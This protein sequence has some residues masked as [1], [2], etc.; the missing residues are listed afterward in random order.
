MMKQRT[1]FLLAVFVFLV[2]TSSCND[3]NSPI[4]TQN[5]MKEQNNQL[6]LQMMQK[7]KMKFMLI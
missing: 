1:C 3:D 7:V 4:K 2:T 6:L 5:L